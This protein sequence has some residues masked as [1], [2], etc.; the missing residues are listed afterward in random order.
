[1]VL[2]TGRDGPDPIRWSLNC[3]PEERRTIR[4]AAGS[5]LEAS[6][7]SCEATAR[8]ASGKENSDVVEETANAEEQRVVI[9]CRRLGTP[10]VPSPLVKSLTSWGVCSAKDVIDS[11]LSFCGCGV[12]LRQELPPPLQPLSRRRCCDTLDP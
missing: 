10:F 4:A 7:C 6:A 8:V 3:N 1:M 2:V 5:G 9:N 11:E 12:A